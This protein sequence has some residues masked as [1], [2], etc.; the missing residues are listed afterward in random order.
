[1]NLPKI[2]ENDE[3]VLDALTKRIEALSDGAEPRN[4]SELEALSQSYHQLARRASERYLQ[5]NLN[6][7]SK[8]NSA[9]LWNA[10]CAVSENE[11]FKLLER[12]AYG[13]PKVFD[14]ALATGGK[15]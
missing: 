14:D 3:V 2:V 12:V 4:E 1:M 15:Q 10:F 8:G 6:A 5:A 7:A 9:A 13:A 11:Q